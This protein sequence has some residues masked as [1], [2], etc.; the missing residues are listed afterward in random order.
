L[1]LIAWG[2]RN[3]VA[4]MDIF[5]KGEQKSAKEKKRGQGGWDNTNSL[6]GGISYDPLLLEPVALCWREK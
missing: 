6:T 3:P 2:D 1:D 5:A 4:K